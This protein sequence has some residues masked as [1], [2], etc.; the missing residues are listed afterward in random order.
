MRVLR[1]ASPVS[2]LPCI[3]WSETPN[4][5]VQRHFESSSKPNVFLAVRAL[6]VLELICV[7]VGGLMQPYPEPGAPFMKFESGTPVATDVRPEGFYLE[8]VDEQ[9]AI[10]LHA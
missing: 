3:V 9:A 8:R 7:E 5:P 10:F 2:V 4:G 1:A 6:D